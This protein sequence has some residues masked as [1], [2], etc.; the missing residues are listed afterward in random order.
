VAGPE[1]DKETIVY[2]DID[3]KL[4]AMAKS[5]INLTGSYSRWDILNLNVREE[6]YE[7]LVP[8]ETLG[9]EIQDSGVAEVENLKDQI[10]SLQ[11]RLYELESMAKGE[12][13]P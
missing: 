2:G 12:H 5:I 3:L 10:K 13:Q 9:R 4:N 1:I 6:L 7:P 11:D 8:M